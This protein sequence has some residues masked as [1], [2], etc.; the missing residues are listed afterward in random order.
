DSITDTFAALRLEVDNWR[1]AGVPFYLRTGKRLPQRDTEITIQFRRAPLILLPAAQRQP[2]NRL[3]IHVQPDERIALNFHAKCPGPQLRLAPVEMAFTY[4]DPDGDERRTGHETL[5]YDAMSGDATSFHR[6][7]MIDA[8][9]RV[10]TPV[11]E[12]WGAERP[13]DFPNYTAGTW[14][15]RCAEE[16][17]ARDGRA[18]LDPMP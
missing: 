16:L 13:A 4:T 8:A 15:P 18:W 10:V 5:L 14:G 12:A 2:P 6:A 17:I 9:W 7:D 1:W 11:L 3:V